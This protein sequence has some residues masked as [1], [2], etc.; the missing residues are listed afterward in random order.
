MPATSNDLYPTI[1]E[2]AGLP[3]RPHQHWTVEAWQEPESEGPS[4]KTDLL[5]LPR[6]TN[7]PRAPLTP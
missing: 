3:M 4:R 5:A 1:L 2:M 6:T 7:I